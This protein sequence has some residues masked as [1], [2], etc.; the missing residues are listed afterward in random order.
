MDVKIVFG[1][2]AGVVMI[3]GVIGGFVGNDEEF[4]QVGDLGYRVSDIGNGSVLVETMGEND[5]YDWF[6]MSNTT[7]DQ[8]KGELGIE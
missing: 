8:L 7:V 2:I 3:G 5:S 1:I 6:I 4:V